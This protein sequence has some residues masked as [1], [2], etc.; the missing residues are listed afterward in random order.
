MATTHT[1]SDF[2]ASV[3]GL[4]MR[5]TPL[6]ESGTFNP[7]VGIVSFT[8]KQFLSLGFT[9]EYEDGDEIT[10]KTA[11][12]SVCVQ[13]KAPDVMKNVSIDFS[14]C[15]P[16]PELYHLL[17]GGTKLTDTI[18]LPNGATQDD[19]IVGWRSPI[20]G[21][22]PALPVCIEVWSRAVVGG[23]MATTRPYWH[24]VFPQVSLRLSGD[25][26]LENGLMANGFEGQ[27][28]GSTP[29][30]DLISVYTDA[31]WNEAWGTEA[32]YQY[33][34]VQTIPIAFGPVYVEDK[35]QS[36]APPSSGP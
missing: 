34:R 8:T 14:I 26:T 5:I 12:G 17:A 35:P 30:N 23:K 21:Q 33:A 31:G 32:P 25:R 9:P 7:E 11:D 20:I 29:V 36:A 28:V 3:Q 13:Y 24:W 15:S 22:T 19:V 18:D 1:P 10:E 6:T 16:E 2:A 4:A 27:G